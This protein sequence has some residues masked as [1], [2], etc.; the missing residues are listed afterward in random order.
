MGLCRDRNTPCRKLA[1]TPECCYVYNVPSCLPSTSK[2]D[3]LMDAILKC[4]KCDLIDE[5]TV[6]TNKQRVC[7][8]NNVP[9]SEKLSSE[10]KTAPFRDKSAVHHDAA[11][12][13]SLHLLVFQ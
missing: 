4:E 10:S 3:I 1:S 6:W 13:S 7:K 5:R 8:N 9:F 12:V 11:E 2:S